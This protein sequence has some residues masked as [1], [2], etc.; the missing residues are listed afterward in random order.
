MIGNN[1]EGV[2][3]KF[4]PNLTLFLLF[5]WSFVTDT[6]KDFF[7]RDLQLHFN[8]SNTFGTMKIC[9]RQR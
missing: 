2:L 7:Y 3:W 9:S 8:C 6:V 4:I 5:I 1:F